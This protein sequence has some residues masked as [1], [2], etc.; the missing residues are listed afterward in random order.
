[1]TKPNVKSESGSGADQVIN[2]HGLSATS[3]VGPVHPSFP[4]LHPQLAAFLQG[5][6]R[7]CPWVLTCRGDAWL[8]AGARHLSAVLVHTPAEVTLPVALQGHE[9]AQVIAL[10]HVLVVP[11]C[12]TVVLQ[13]AFPP[14]L[15]DGPGPLGGL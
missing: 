3:S 14:A 4:H 7:C 6:L 8:G 5:H 2:Q 15:T 13:Q 12:A 9:V 1:M 10:G 11:W